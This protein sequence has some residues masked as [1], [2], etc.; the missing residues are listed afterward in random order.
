MK[1]SEQL[2][3]VLVKIGRRDRLHCARINVPDCDAMIP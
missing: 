3:D 2:V 1:I